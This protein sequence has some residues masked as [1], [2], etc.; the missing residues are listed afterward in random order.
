VDIIWLYQIPNWLLC[1]LVVGVFA[2]VSLVGLKLTRP[3]V[4]SFK[5]H[6][7]DIVASFA[8]SVGV[9]YAVLLAMIAVAAWTNYTTVDSLAAQEAD[10]VHSLFRDIE[11]YP[12]FERDELRGLLREYVD[13][14]IHTEWPALQKG[15]TDRRAALV[16]DSIFSGWIKLDP[17][18]EAQKI[19][20]AE[21]LA[22]LNLFQSVRQSRLQTGGNGL[23]AVLWVVVLAG[24]VVSIGICY[25][26]W[27]ENKLLHQV[28]ISI[29]GGMI[30]VVVYLI[31]A[32]DHPM[33]GAITIRP[34]AFEAVAASMDRVLHP[35]TPG[36]RRVSQR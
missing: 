24:A 12:Q 7:N 11:A 18:T 22:R 13:T 8:A 20:N 21:T 16:V 31:L 14:V 4:S 29:L 6:H 34:T 26:F 27:I 1:L 2:T 10:L 17:R 30:G 15:S 3:W 23:D 33:W 35:L 28:M 19:V 36:E 9:L 25:L 5:T 32:L